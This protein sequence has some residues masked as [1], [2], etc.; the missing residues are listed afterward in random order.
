MQSLNMNKVFD[1]FLKGFLKI[2]ASILA[3]KINIFFQKLFNN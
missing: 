1:A 2:K 3:S